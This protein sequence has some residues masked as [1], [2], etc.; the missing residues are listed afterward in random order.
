MFY[1]QLLVIYN[2]LDARKIHMHVHTFN[3]YTETTHLS[4]YWRKEKYIK[5]HYMPWESLGKFL[6]ARVKLLKSVLNAQGERTVL[7]ACSSLAQGTWYWKVGPWGQRRPRPQVC[8]WGCFGCLVINTLLF[9]P[10]ISV[11]RSAWPPSL[12]LSDNNLGSYF[13]PHTLLSENT[14]LIR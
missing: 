10:T 4:L 9:T 6:S 2:L 7:V 11:V 5:P 14:Q 1:K 8:N 12:L 3:S 13:V